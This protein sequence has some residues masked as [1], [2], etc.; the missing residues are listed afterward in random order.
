MPTPFEELISCMNAEFASRQEIRHMQEHPDELGWL[1]G[2][3]ALRAKR[4]QYFTQKD[5][6]DRALDAAVTP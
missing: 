2:E 1:A 5:D 3:E 6:T 4:S